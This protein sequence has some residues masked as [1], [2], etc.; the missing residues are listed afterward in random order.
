MGEINL[1]NGRLYS[2][3]EEVG[4]RVVI[5]CFEFLITN[6]IYIQSLLVPYISRKSAISDF[7]FHIFQHN[8]LIKH[9][10]SV[11][12]DK[13]YLRS[14]WIPYIRRSHLGSN[15][16]SGRIPYTAPEG[17]LPPDWADYRPTW[18]S[19]ANHGAGTGGWGRCDR[20]R[21]P[22]SGNDCNLGPRTFASRS[23]FC[24]LVSSA[25]SPP[26]PSRC[27]IE[28]GTIVRDWGGVIV[29]KDI[30]N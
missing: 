21:R 10:N 12:F 15:R 29:V 27:G 26:D 6:I 22:A 16:R 7:Q 18:R 4:D 8:L 24:G 13:A 20:K 1:E 2:T 23:P 14:V 30:Q 11:H 3:F 17:Q 28:A 19:L 9:F 5:L 25:Q